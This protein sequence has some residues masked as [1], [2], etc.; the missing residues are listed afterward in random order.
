MWGEGRSSSSEP[1]SSLGLATACLALFVPCFLSPFILEWVAGGWGHSSGPSYS[2]QAHISQHRRSS[3]LCPSSPL[4]C[5]SW[6]GTCW[7]G[8]WL[9]PRGAEESPIRGAVAFLLGEG[10]EGLEDPP[11]LWAHPSPGQRP[12]PLPPWGETRNGEVPLLILLKTMA[13]TFQWAPRSSNGQGD[14]RARLCQ[15]LRETS[16]PGIHRLVCGPHERR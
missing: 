6:F 15:H 14:P 4:P 12:Q 3:L 11:P 13:L 7:G 9:G 8:A 16:H 1:S 5:G 2:G 10:K